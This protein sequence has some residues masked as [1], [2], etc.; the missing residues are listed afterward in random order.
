M[1]SS[2]KNLNNDLLAMEQGVED[3]IIN[4]YSVVER[5]ALQ[6]LADKQ[7]T[8]RSIGEVNDQY[9]ALKR[10]GIIS[11]EK[12]TSRQTSSVRWG[13]TCSALVDGRRRFICTG[14]CVS[15]A[16]AKLIVLI[17]MGNLPIK[18]VRKAKQVRNKSCICD[19]G[20]L[21]Y[22][23][24]E[25]KKLIRE[26]GQLSV[27]RPSIINEALG[28]ERLINVSDA[29]SFIAFSSITSRSSID[30]HAEYSKLRMSMFPPLSTSAIYGVP[31]SIPRRLR[32]RCY[33]GRRLNPG[34]I[35]S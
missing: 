31:A 8:V 21:V 19:V 18:K 28:L 14:L 23:Y 35:P 17:R 2:H 12:M 16:V 26:G 9:S 11:D 25:A 22:K 10:M 7:L 27:D 6:M 13:V 1:V 5:A 24:V 32:K 30:P 33:L 3:G 34:L 15:L 29:P 4:S 20:K